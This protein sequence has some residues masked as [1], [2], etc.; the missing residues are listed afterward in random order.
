M[1]HSKKYF[2][3]INGYPGVGKLT[4]AKELRYAR[5]MSML[6]SR[7]L[8]P[9]ARLLDNHKLIDPAAALFERGAPEYQP[10]RQAIVLI[11][12]CSLD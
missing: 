2:V 6:I 8:M 7:L 5:F 4:I 12:N 1:D 9:G 11:S 10:L 3:Y